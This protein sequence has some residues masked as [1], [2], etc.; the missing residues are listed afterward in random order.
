M[1]AGR[2]ATADRVAASSAERA[3]SELKRGPAICFS[4]L[5]PSG[6]RMSSSAASSRAVTRRSR[7]FGLENLL[8]LSCPAQLVEV[9][10]EVGPLEELHHLARCAAHQQ[11]GL[12]QVAG[13]ELF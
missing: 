10:H 4:F 13:A 1:A 5:H 8:L 3:D 9:L 12:P 2:T 11:P 7:S 6:S